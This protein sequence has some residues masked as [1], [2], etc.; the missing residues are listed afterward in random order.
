M[1]EFLETQKKILEEIEKDIREVEGVKVVVKHVDGAKPEDLLI[2]DGIIVGS[3]A[4]CG[5]L[6][7]K[8]KKFFDESVSVA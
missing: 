8:L 5:T 3:P 2:Y 7:W 6:T 1:I 4:Y